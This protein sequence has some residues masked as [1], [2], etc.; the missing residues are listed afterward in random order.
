MTLNIQSPAFLEG[1]EIPKK[2]GYKNG[3]T[4][5]PLRIDGIPA[6]CQSLALIMDDPDAKAAVGKIWVH[7]ILWNI[8]SDTQEIS[9]SEIP[10]G[11][12]EGSTDFGEVGYG[13]PAPPDKR[14][15][16]VF[17][18]YAL[19]AVLELSESADKKQLEDAMRDHILEEAKLTGTYAPQ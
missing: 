1:E 8:P 9:E 12:Q 19:D 2:Y 10:S 7:W 5:P 18:L 14:H 3:N 13:G 11:C 4:S 16:Y 17:R 15:T 6:R